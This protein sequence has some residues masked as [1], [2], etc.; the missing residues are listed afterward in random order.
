MLVTVRRQ[1]KK[2]GVAVVGGLLVA[3]GGAM[4]V[5]PGPGLLVVLAGLLVLADEFPAVERFV[6]PVRERAMRAAEESVS[7]PLRL[8]GSTVFGLGL[9][10]MGAVW[11]YDPGVPFGGLSVGLSLVVS[12]LAV[13]ALL[14][15]SYRRTH[16]EQG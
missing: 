6:E 4:L 11:A 16:R 8:A 14:V 9:I 12:G 10:A 7:T 15:Y 2:V 5:L 1:L 13:L 3:A